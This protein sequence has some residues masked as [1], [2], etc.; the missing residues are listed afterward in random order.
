MLSACA[1]HVQRGFAIRSS[2]HGE[3]FIMASTT[4]EVERAAHNYRH[5]KLER[6]V[7]EVAQMCKPDSVHW[8][9]GS[10][11]E[12]QEMLRLMVLTGTA[13]P[14]DAAK[15]PNSVLLPSSTDP[16]VARRSSSRGCQSAIRNSPRACGLPSPLR[17]RGRRPWSHRAPRPWRARSRAS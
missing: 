7:E 11:E 4:I 16:A 9:D 8:C 15:R 3:R 14:L 10:P 13:I 2:L 5:P 17:R 1:N 6:W 12:Y